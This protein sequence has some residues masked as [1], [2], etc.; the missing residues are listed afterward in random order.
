MLCRRNL[1]TF[2][3][4]LWPLCGIACQKT[5]FSENHKTHRNI[6]FACRLSHLAWKFKENIRNSLYK[7]ISKWHCEIR[8]DGF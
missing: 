5:V 6:S 3:N 7:F 4:K 1:P 8:G 2:Q